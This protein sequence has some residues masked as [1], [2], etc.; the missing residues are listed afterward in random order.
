[1]KLQYGLALA[2]ALAAC[3]KEEPLLLDPV[4]ESK[5]EATKPIEKTEE[6]V[7]NKAI[8]PQVIQV[9]PEFIDGQITVKLT[10]GQVYTFSS[11]EYMVVR[12][13]SSAK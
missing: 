4:P 8:R 3:E 5:K 2:L 9:P 1:M 6:H 11:N 7:P 13:R 12:R 10:D